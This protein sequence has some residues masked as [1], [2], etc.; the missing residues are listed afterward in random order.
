MVKT[1]LFSVYD[2]Q[3][4]NKP[5][6]LNESQRR[7]ELRKAKEKYKSKWFWDE[8]SKYFNQRQ[9]DKLI[10]VVFEIFFLYLKN[11]TKATCQY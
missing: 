11:I 3:V 1:R 9:S 6:P 7:F 5:N 8:S 10:N 4:P 2:K